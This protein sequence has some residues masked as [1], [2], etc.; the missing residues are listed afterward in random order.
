MRSLPDGS[1]LYRELVTRAPEPM[2]ITDQRGL[3]RFE[4]SP[5][6]RLT[7]EAGE[8]PPADLRI[9]HAGDHDRLRAAFERRHC[10]ILPRSSTAASAISTAD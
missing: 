8:D 9:R 4:N 2:I 6:S 3:I 5:A 1:S 7:G 10:A